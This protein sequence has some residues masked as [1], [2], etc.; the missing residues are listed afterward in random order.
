MESGRPPDALE[1]IPLALQETDRIVATAQ[2]ELTTAEGRYPL[3]AAL[4]LQ[5]PSYL[6]LEMLPVI[7]TPDLFLTATPDEM[8]IFIPSL[9]EFYTGKPS[10]EN[11]ARFL[12]WALKVEDIVMILSGAY[13]VP[14]GENISYERFAE[15]R[16]LRTDMKT[17][18]GF[19][20]KVWTMQNGSVAKFIRYGPDGKE[21]YQVQYEDYAPS[22]PL[23]ET[24]N[25]QWA[26]NKM[27]VSVKY[28]DW[29]LE[30]ATDGSVFELSVPAGMKSR[31]LD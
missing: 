16:L 2:I 21:A 7:G 10:A 5:R 12:P 14:A 31:R 24:I 29:K 4:I 15:G 18:S 22:S 30:K 1:S 6:R 13:P 26:D 20:Q 3:R 25:I 19:L 17:P 28:S 11:V 8:R 27:S 23:A 9:G